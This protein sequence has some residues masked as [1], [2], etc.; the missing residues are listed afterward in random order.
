[1]SL[2]VTHSGVSRHNRRVAQPGSAHPSGGWGRR[3]ESSHADHLSL[4]N[5]LFMIYLSFVFDVVVLGFIG[6]SRYSP[7]KSALFRIGQPLFVPSLLISALLLPVFS[8]Q[9]WPR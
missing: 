5:Q 2:P 9:N 7:G 4:Y 6:E 3:F 1:M 8:A